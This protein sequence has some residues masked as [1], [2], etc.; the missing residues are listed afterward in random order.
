[1]AENELDLLAIGRIGMMRQTQPDLFVMRLKVVAG[2]LSAAQLARIASVAE[3]YG[4]GFV[5][6]ST[7]QGVEI[8]YV[9]KDNLETARLELESAGIE[10]GACGA[11]VRGVV[12]C[13][14]NETCRMGV[15]DT[16]KIAKELD[17]RYFKKD[18]PSKFKMAV[19]GCSSNCTKANENDIGIRGAIEP[20]WVAPTCTDCGLCISLCPVNAIERKEKAGASPN[21]HAYVIDE[22]RCINCSVCTSHCP[23]NAW[24][25]GRQGYNL[26]IGGT[27]GKIP[28]F[29]TLLKKLVESEEE[30]YLLVESAFAFY[31]DNGYKKERFGH[32]ID[33]IGIENVREAIFD[34]A[35]LSEEH[36][37]SGDLLSCQCSAGQSGNC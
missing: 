26:Y 11:R 35:Q 12:A 15:I 31:K 1:M 22:E 5:H 7:R 9:H 14:G 23:T 30:L 6:L 2:D 25:I 24:V 10:M 19:T 17:A 13:P 36:R 32:M 20:R 37:C 27:M 28:R 18:T 16:K 21:D 33:R 3:K 8:H 4:R 34:A 29:A